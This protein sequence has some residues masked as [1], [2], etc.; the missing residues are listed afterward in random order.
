MY[1][2]TGL[3]KLVF[4]IYILDSFAFAARLLWILQWISTR[5]NYQ[6]FLRIDDDHFLCLERLLFDLPFRPNRALYWGFVHCRPNIVRVDEGWLILTKD[7][8]DEIL[9]KA[10]TTLLC[11]PYGDQ[12][13]ALWMNNSTYN[14]TYFVDNQRII[15]KT[16]GYD[17]KY[18]KKTVCEEYL[19]LHGVF[20]HEMRKLWLIS[21]KLY[22]ARLNSMPQYNIT[23]IIPFEKLCPYSKVFSTEGFYPEYRFEPRPCRMKPSWSI[24]RSEHV[25]REEAGERYSS[26]WVSLL[27]Q[28]R[29][30]M[31][32]EFPKVWGNMNDAI[33][34]T[35]KDNDCTFTCKALPT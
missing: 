22:R 35:K 15:H 17:P 20:H 3:P 27:P 1:L 26:Y 33:D 11:H 28:D 34:G 25:S 29:K 6:Y 18:Y 31:I 24:S 5:Y 12:A 32:S 30:D 14:V 10:D 16:T 9:N 19:S 8:V 13:V 2:Y 23:P 4:L 7:L 21:H